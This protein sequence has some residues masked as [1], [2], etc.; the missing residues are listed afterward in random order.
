MKQGIDNIV[1]QLKTTPTKDLKR[2]YAE[3]FGHK[4]SSNNK[5]W[6]VKRIAWGVQS[7]HQNLDISKRA[8]E[9]AIELA[10]TSEIRT[11]IPKFKEIEPESTTVTKPIRFNV[12]SRLPMPG[13]ILTK[14][15]KGQKIEV[16]VLSDG[17]LYRGRH[18]RSL[19]AVAKVISGSHCN[20]FVFFGLKKG[21]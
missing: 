12:D 19:S 3:L 14:N 21:N 17:F 11:T 2:K 10:K 20:G 5:A 8:R 4:P 1:T 7:H 6:L 18:Y 16:T 15:Y 13:A 9:R